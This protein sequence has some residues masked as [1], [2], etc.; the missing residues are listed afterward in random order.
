MT[1]RQN[2]IAAGALSQAEQIKIYSVNKLVEKIKE[3]FP[4][5]TNL[6]I[7]INFNYI[8]KSK[9]DLYYVMPL[10]LM[11]NNKLYTDDEFEKR[12][13]I[14]TFLFNVK[15]SQYNKMSMRKYITFW[16]LDIDCSKQIESK[17]FKYYNS[18]LLCIRDQKIIEMISPPPDEFYFPI[19]EQQ[20]LEDE[21]END[22]MSQVQ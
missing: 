15:N 5:M 14:E 1:S 8:K 16:C 3:K 21:I 20:A 4:G 18:I 22:L 17:G 19:D 6:K 9:I 2:E 10:A 7:F 12:L 13:G 11:I